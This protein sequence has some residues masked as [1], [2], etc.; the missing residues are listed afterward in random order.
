MYGSEKFRNA[1]IKVYVLEF[2]Y[3]F[4]IYIEMLKYRY[5]RSCKMYQRAFTDVF[6]YFQV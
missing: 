6:L 1:K 4:Y 3:I 5:L 2:V